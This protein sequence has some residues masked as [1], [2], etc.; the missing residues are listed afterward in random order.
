MKSILLV[1]AGLAVVFCVSA[2]PV[3]ADTISDTFTLMK[4]GKVVETLTLTEAEEGT[5]GKTITFTTLFPLGTG[6]GAGGVAGDA[7]SFVPTMDMKN[8]MLQ[9]FSDGDKG[10]GKDPQD[11][12]TVLIFGKNGK[13]SAVAD[14]LVIQSDVPAPEPGTITLLCA[15][16]VGLGLWAKARATR[17]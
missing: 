1:L 12:L 7:A 2:S 14:T 3:S 11:S 15:G 9:V 6:F 16:L 4:G 13:P 17:G 5:K 10:G 8:L